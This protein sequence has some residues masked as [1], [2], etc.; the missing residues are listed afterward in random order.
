MS[1]NNGITF[2]YIPSIPIPAQK[3]LDT[4][5]AYNQQTLQA[6]F[7]FLNSQIMADSQIGLYSYAYTLGQLNQYVLNQLV[8]LG[9]IVTDNTNYNGTPIS[10]IY[11]ISWVPL[12][13]P[14]A[15]Q[16]A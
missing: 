16:P 2:P 14:P 12:N 10:Y 1:Q 8:S 7:N 3:A 9:Y 15:G 11:N 6:I 5:N 13:F 4:A